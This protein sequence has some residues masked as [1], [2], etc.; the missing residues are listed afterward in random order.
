[1]ISVPTTPKVL[2]RS[3]AVRKDWMTLFVVASERSAM[4]PGGKSRPGM[5]KKQ[6]IRARRGR[7][8]MK[9]VR[10]LFVAEESNGVLVGL[11][12]DRQ[13]DAKRSL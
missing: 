13:A 12:R 8:E 1:M 9:W 10:R 6:E 11:L 2:A 5:V 4:S 7:R 3:R